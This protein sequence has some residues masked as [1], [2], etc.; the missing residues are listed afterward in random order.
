VTP[1]NIGLKSP[2]RNKINKI[3]F[4]TIII[5]A[6]KNAQSRASSGLKTY[7]NN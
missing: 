1:H 2:R 7:K 6:H 3:F 4:S 5:L